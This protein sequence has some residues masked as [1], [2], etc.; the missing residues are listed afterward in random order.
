MR[1]STTVLIVGG[2]P[3]GATAATFLARNGVEVTLLERDTFPRYH[4]G[5]SLSL[6]VVRMM[7]ILGVSEK[8]NS[9]GFRHKGGSYYEW[10]SEKWDLPFTD[11]PGGKHSWQVVRSEF[12]KLLLDHARDEGVEVHE[13][14]R[15]NSIRFDDDRAVA[16]LWQDNDGNE[17]ELTFDYVIDASGRAGLLSRNKFKNR[18]VHEVFRNIGVW[19]YWN[20]AKDIEPGPDGAVSVC[21]VPEGWIWVIPLHNGVTSIGLVTDKE[22]FYARR[23]SPEDVQVIYDQAIRSHPLVAETIMNAEQISKIRTETDYSYVADSFCG[24]GYLMAGDSACFLDPLLSTGVHLATFSAMLAAAAVTSIVQGGVAEERALTFYDTAYRYSYE[25]LLVVVSVFYDSYRGK[26][27]YFYRGQSLT[28]SEVQRLHIHEAFLSIIAGVEDLEDAS[29][30]NAYKAIEERLHGGA[31]GEIPPTRVHSQSREWQIMP[32][33]PATAI[34]GMY[35]EMEPSPRL[36]D[37]L[38]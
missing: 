17:D 22:R 14:H 28:R 18:R 8:L 35:L 12:D 20:G 13:G 9:H 5:E 3:A 30:M 36:R 21:S 6:S 1:P 24:P 27:D 38:K 4:V 32:N 37:T 34:Q 11:V 2:G 31:P 23:K 7:D 15:V 25:R 10:G 29:T 16:A 19:A 26:D 33:S